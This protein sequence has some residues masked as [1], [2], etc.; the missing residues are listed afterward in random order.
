MKTAEIRA[1]MAN[2]MQESKGLIEQYPDF[3]FPDDVYERVKSIDSELGDLKGKLDNAN[4][5][6]EIVERMSSFDS[7]LNE[8]AA[9]SNGTTHAG[10][11]GGA[12]KAR[13]SDDG[14]QHQ[15]Q[16]H[17]KAV[18]Q[19]V[20]GDGEYS[21]WLKKVAP[22]GNFSEKVRVASPQ[23]QIPGG[24]KALVT[25][26]SDSSA[27]AF[28][29]TDVQRNLDQFILRRPLVMRD[30]ITIGRTESDM[31]EYVRQVSE[32][33]NAAM[34]PEATSS[35]P[36]GDGTGGTVLPAAGGL[37]PQSA[38][39][40][41]RVTTPVRTVAHWMPATKRALSDAGQME[42]LIDNFL[43]Y[44]V[45]EELED[46]MVI[47]DGTGENF[48]GLANIT[49]LTAQNWDTNLMVTTR[50]AKTKVRTVG[51]MSPTAYLLNPYDWESIQ[52]LRTEDGGANTGQFFFGGP[53]AVE[54]P[55]LWNLPVV[56]SESVPVGTGYVGNFK[57][58]I[59]WD[60]EQAGVQMTD[61]HNDF[62]VRNLVAILAEARA[63]FG[64]LRPSAIVEM[65]LTA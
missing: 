58:L 52:L 25:G 6:K 5:S 60:R 10:D 16:Q 29:F 26:A 42:T 65:D 8:P 44:G 24:L 4:R 40:F 54:V 20:L 53:A 13:G 35:A 9:N 48:Y 45:E 36:I 41:E 11:S 21:D 18:S 17:R 63:A 39:V 47:G 50:R 64:C 49:N 14:A 56:E 46:Q 3:S 57:T 30:I 19:I 59:L 38:M 23:V 31:V 28:V 33:N 7:Y 32:T 2:L 62:F 12:G 15:H 22:S 61:S 55:T 51:R 43:R 34:V 37:K 1:R 27:G